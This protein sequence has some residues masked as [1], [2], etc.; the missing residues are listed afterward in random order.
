MKQ[1]H[2]EEDLEK[3]GKKT[4]RDPQQRAGVKAMPRPSAGG[5]G[6]RLSP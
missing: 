4:P 1:V 6:Y 2:E 5:F 3:R